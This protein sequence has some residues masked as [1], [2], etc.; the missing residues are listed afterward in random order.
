MKDGNPD[1]WRELAHLSGQYN[2]TQQDPLTGIIPCAGDTLSN[3]LEHLDKEA[4][5]PAG[6]TD[7]K[8]VIEAGTT[9]D[10]ITLSQ[11]NLRNSQIFRLAKSAA[12]ASGKKLRV[13]N[14]DVVPVTI[15]GNGQGK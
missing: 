5:I 13:E 11:H 7:A 15:D 1:R 9:D 10:A 2:G 6:E 12:E 3:F 8:A 4:G 14:D